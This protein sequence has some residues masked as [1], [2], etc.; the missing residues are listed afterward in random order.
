MGKTG[1]GFP[2]DTGTQD[3]NCHQAQTQ[4]IERSVPLR[5]LKMHQRRQHGEH[6]NTGINIKQKPSLRDSHLCYV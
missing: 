6:K 4:E 2:I 5:S 3:N 1:F